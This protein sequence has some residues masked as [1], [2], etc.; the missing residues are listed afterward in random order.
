M[1]TK[2][3][4]PPRFCTLQP[5]LAEDN[6]TIILFAL[7]TAGQ[8][9]WRTVHGEAWVPMRMDKSTDPKKS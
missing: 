7:D 9:W 5:V 3:K 2:A 1:S 4:K 8:V 6:R